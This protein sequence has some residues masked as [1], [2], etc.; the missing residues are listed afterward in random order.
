MC[1]QVCYRNNYL[2]LNRGETCDENVDDC[3][4]HDCKNG[5]V[6]IDGQDE[7]SCHC[8]HGYHGDYCQLSKSN[9]REC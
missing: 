4:D 5:A 7:Y 3:V 2:I 8:K 1:S 9:V 6:C